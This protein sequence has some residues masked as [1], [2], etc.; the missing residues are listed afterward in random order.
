MQCP[1]VSFA[2]IS[3]PAEA[4]Q[5]YL[6]KAG[7][8]GAVPSVVTSPASAT[9][10]VVVMPPPHANAALRGAA[11]AFR[12]ASQ[13]PMP[14]PQMVT[15]QPSHIFLSHPNQT[16]VVN[17]AFPPPPSSML[18]HQPMHL[19][20]HVYHQPALRS[21]SSQPSIHYSYHHQ[22]P[23]QA[24]M[25]QMDMQ[26]VGMAF[27]QQGAMGPHPTPT[28]QPLGPHS[29]QQGLVQQH[30]VMMMPST[31]C[32]STHTVH[33]TY[34]ADDMGPIAGRVMGE[35]A[36]ELYNMDPMPMSMSYGQG[37]GLSG[38]GNQSSLQTQ[39]PHYPAAP[40]AF[41]TTES[42]VPSDIRDMDDVTSAAATGQTLQIPP[43]GSPAS[44]PP[45]QAAQ[46]EDAQDSLTLPTN[47]FGDE[48]WDD[49]SGIPIINV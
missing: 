2:S 22:M 48:H 8:N 4:V 3:V 13:F 5:D 12:A 10:A 34:S 26:S 46:Q 31:A 23:Q 14:A 25:P 37:Q 42:W 20:S 40:P 24:W 16:M 32:S 44:S 39:Q 18:Q 15:T 29:H 49:A 43:I 28:W 33:R 41:L 19:V 1:H 36:Q 9:S 30:P 7:S 17:A 38:G 27:V 35:W 11:S 45:M 21:C 47:W 6:S